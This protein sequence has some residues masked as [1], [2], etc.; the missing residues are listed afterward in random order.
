VKLSGGVKLNDAVP[1]GTRREAM[2]SLELIFDK[3]GERWFALWHPRAVLGREPGFLT[4]PPTFPNRM[5]YWYRRIVPYFYIERR[6][7]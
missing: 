2:R 4:L 3:T 6:A 5:R 7:P 1:V